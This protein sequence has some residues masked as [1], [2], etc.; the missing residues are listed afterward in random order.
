MSDVASCV[1][2]K[3]SLEAG[4]SKHSSAVMMTSHY[5]GYQPLPGVHE[6]T[7]SLSP[8]LPPEQFF[9]DYVVMRRP[10][11]FSGS[12]VDE[13]WRGSK[14]TLSYLLHKAGSSTVTVEDR[15]A[16]A[17]STS[18]LYLEMH[19]RD[20]VSSLLAGETRYHLTNSDVQCSMSDL[21][22]R[23]GALATVLQP[24]QTLADDFPLRPAILGNLI[25]HQVAE[26]HH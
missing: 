19:Y 4:N 16:P 21:R 5:S 15:P 20:F 6:L 14:W 9:N 24:L 11:V 26:A 25:P 18:V 17:D 23:N 7:D 12:L 13:P 2:R 1:S 22:D 3:R 10:A 8:D